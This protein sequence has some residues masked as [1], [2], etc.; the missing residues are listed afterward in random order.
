MDS[1]NITIVDEICDLCLQS[2]SQMSWL[3]EPL[4]AGRARAFIL[5]HIL[6]N[7]LLSSVIRPA[8]V[9]RCLASPTSPARTASLMGVWTR[10]T[11]AGCWLRGVPLRATQTRPAT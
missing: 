11:S 5:Q 1:K 7:R 2:S 4:T 3:I 9:S 10:S 8:W 6:R